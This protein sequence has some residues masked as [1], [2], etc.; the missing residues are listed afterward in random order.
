VNR[1]A[2]RAPAPRPTRPPI[3]PRRVASGAEDRKQAALVRWVHGG[4]E[5]MVSGTFNQ[6][7]EPVPLQ[8][9]GCGRGSAARLLLCSLRRLSLLV[10]GRDGTFQTT[11]L[12]APGNYEYKF[13]VDGQWRHDPSPSAATIRNSFGSVN[14]MLKVR[15]GSTSSRRGEFAPLPPLARSRALL[16]VLRARARVGCAVDL[17][18]IGGP[19]QPKRSLCRGA[20]PAHGQLCGPPQRYGGGIACVLSARSAL[21]CYFFV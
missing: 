1:I 6:W 16:P 20:S 18:R 17:D 4:S 9:Q 5:V 13:I 2:P 12:L 21:S 10:H 8:P 11:L 15:W 19:K 14:N 7:K 3:R